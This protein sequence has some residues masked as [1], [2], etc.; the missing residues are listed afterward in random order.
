MAS[1]PKQAKDFWEGE[2]YRF[3]GGFFTIW[4]G[5]NC[6]VASARYGVDQGIYWWVGNLTLIGCAV[7]LLKKHRG[8]LIATLSFTAFSQVVWNLDN[9][10][11]LVTGE[12]LFG[13]I[14][15]LYQPGMRLD[16]FFL[17]HSAYVSVPV[18]LFALFRLPRKKSNALQL[19]LILDPIIYLVS[20]F[21]FQANQNINCTHWSCVPAFQDLAGVPYSIG[22]G[23][24]VL[25]IHIGM[26]LLCEKI[27]LAMPRARAFKNKLVHALGIVATLSVV[28]FSLEMRYRNTLPL[29]R[30]SSQYDDGRLRV[31]CRYARM[32][33][34]D[35]M[36][37]SYTAEN[38]SNDPQKCTTLIRANGG[39]STLDGGMVFLPRE[40][41]HLDVLIPYP[42][43]S[44]VLSLAASC[45]EKT[46]RSLST[47]PR[48]ST[49]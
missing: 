33:S 38:L 30:C 21:A 23:I 6:F 18:C 26:G 49:R 34:A 15:A 32:Y 40:K 42:R 3:A 4:V 27:F 16:E 9:V 2:W 14:E 19:I 37:F 43:E 47:A 11:R 36:L 31:D 46:E 39:E 29:L 12:N 24:L 41:K 1:K 17:S 7:G 10:W 8:W 48:S 5:A 22:F 25:A 44:I 35:V 20:Y 45:Q 13:F 28:L